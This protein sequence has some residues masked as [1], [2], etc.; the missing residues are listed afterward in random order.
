MNSIA[1]IALLLSA[2]GMAASG[3][4]GLHYEQ[5]KRTCRHG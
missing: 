5:M 2:L 3:L 1:L 4:W